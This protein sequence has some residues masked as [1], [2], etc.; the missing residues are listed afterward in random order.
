MRWPYTGRSDG[1]AVTLDNNVWD[2]LFAR[3][4]ILLDE[5]PCDAFALFI[6]RE[7]EIEGSAIP[8]DAVKAP[9][10]EY[11]Q[12][13]IEQSGIQ[14]TSVFGFSTPGALQRVGGFGQGTWQSATEREF[15]DAIRARFLVGKKET[16]S[17]LT[18]NEG[19]AA[20][21]AQ[22]FF[23]VALTCENPDKAG[24][25]RFAAEHGGKVLYLAG[26]ETSG[27]SLKEY[28]IDCYRKT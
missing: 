3:N 19:D 8:D 14:T 7:V 21:A 12:R 6:T 18:K 5:L 20:V 13:R 24:P 15:Y 27:L 28:V 2:F 4:L 1:R 9:L 11:I 23:S 25:L 22:S 17:R 10:K 26:F 16:R